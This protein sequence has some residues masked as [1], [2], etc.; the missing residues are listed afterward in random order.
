MLMVKQGAL[1]PDIY[2]ELRHKVK[3][4]EYAREDVEMALQ[5]TLFSVVVFQDN[6]PVGMGRVVGD[7][8]IV[9]FIKDVVVDPSYQRQSIG[10]LVMETILDYIEAQACPNAY[11]G[12]MS[13]PKMEAFYEKFGFVK[14]PT[15]DMGHGMV[16]FV[17]RTPMHGHNHDFAK[18]E[19]VQHVKEA[20]HHRYGP[21][22]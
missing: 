14:R 5:R 3:F 8:R 21:R 12:L 2:M 22:D 4:Q 16:K 6:K 7:G 18:E 13:T 17:N 15:E 20:H 1:T 9:F 10:T 11:V 19:A